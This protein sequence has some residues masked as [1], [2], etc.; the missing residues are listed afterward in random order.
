MTPSF[1]LSLTHLLSAILAVIVSASSQAQNSGL[2]SF[3]DGSASASGQQFFHT[4]TQTVRHWNHAFR[5]TGSQQLGNQFSHNIGPLIAPR[6]LPGSPSGVYYLGNGSV[7]GIYPAFPTGFVSFSDFR[8]CYRA[9]VLAYRTPHNHGVNKSPGY[10]HTASTGSLCGVCVSIGSV[11]CAGPIVTPWSL[12]PSTGLFTTD[13]WTGLLVPLNSCSSGYSSGFCGVRMVSPP[14]AAP[15]LPGLVYQARMSAETRTV[16]TPELLALTDPRAL[17]QIAPA[18]DIRPAGHMPAEPNPAVP[19]LGEFPLVSVPEKTTTAADRVESL[20]L[21]SQGDD[22][23]RRRD[24]SKAKQAFEMALQKAPQRAAV[25]F[26]LMMLHVA[27]NDPAQAAACLKTALSLPADGT[28][29]WVSA[30]EIYGP[31]GADSVDAQQHSEQL[32]SWLAERP[33]SADRLLLLGTFAQVRGYDAVAADILTLASHKGAEEERV[34][35]VRA[36]A[37]FRL[38]QPDGTAV[39]PEGLDRVE[40]SLPIPPAP[41]GVAQKQESKTANPIDSTGIVLRG[42][43]KSTAGLPSDIK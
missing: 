39:I 43:R 6:C 42:K 19:L 29:A 28:R 7:S 4:N 14:F 9:S 25:W 22:A 37:A 31:A 20:L 41:E 18:M 12:F 10:F 15:M 8:S 24:Y 13:P 16:M 1:R 33:L 34:L 26:R 40:G 30:K 38:P 11:W 17:D 3:L 32:W 2:P 5:H 36:L 35:A 27:F 21:Q 23:F